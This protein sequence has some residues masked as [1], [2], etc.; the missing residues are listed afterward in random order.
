ML[1]N[2]E[3]VGDN[4]NQASK[5]KRRP[6]RQSEDLKIQNFLAKSDNNPETCCLIL[7]NAINVGEVNYEAMKI[8]KPFEIFQT[9]DPL[10]N[11]LKRRQLNLNRKVI[12][13][14]KLNEINDRVLE[15]FTK[16]YGSRNKFKPHGSVLLS[17]EGCMRQ[18]WHT[19]YSED[20]SQFEKSKACFIAIIALMNDTFFYGTNDSNVAKKMELEAGDILI[21]RGVYVHAGSEYD[22]LNYRMHYYIDIPSYKRKQEGDTYLI[23]VENIIEEKY[24]AYYKRRSEGSYNGTKIKLEK[25]RKREEICEN[26]R[27]SRGR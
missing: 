10:V 5:F 26:M 7:K 21:A 13:E 17:L 2:R 6:K 27:K 3:P 25:K 22:K 20:D 23:E 11:D 4:I 14:L 8:Q 16:I 15:I 12:K 18:T 24:G 1:L 9:N 19:D